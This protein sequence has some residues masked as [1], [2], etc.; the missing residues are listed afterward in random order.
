MKIIYGMPDRFGK[1]RLDLPVSKTNPGG[2]I[3]TKACRVFEAW[4]DWYDDV[5]MVE[6]WWDIQEPEAYL[7]VDPLAFSFTEN[8]NDTIRQY[9]THPARFKV[10]YGSE[11]SALNIAYM[12]RERFFRTSDLVTTCCRFQEGVYQALGFKSARFCDPVP[13]EVFYNPN[14]QKELSLIACGSISDIKQSS[15]IVEIF[16]SLKGKMELIYLGGADLW[17]D[18]VTEADIMESEIRHLADKFYYNVPQ[19]TVAKIFARA[20]CGIFDTAHETCSESN[21]EFLMAGGRCYYGLHA[22]WN[23]RPGVHGLDDP[24]QFVNAISSETNGFTQLPAEKKRKES[25]HWALE[26]CSYNTFIEQWRDIIRRCK[27]SS[28]TQV[29]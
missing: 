21:Q 5:E 16:K 20:S 17:G 1:Y 27:M 8:I 9:E 18:S 10:L 14:Q 7:V 6:N 22:L 28:S 29:P 19:A 15:K 11:L 13:E 23:E 12:H 3:S 24:L 4:K 25:E 2:G 26:N